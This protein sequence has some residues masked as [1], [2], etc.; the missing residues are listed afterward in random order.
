VGGWAWPR[1]RDELEAVQRE[2][3]AAV[4]EPWTVPDGPY[5]LGAAFVAFSTGRGRAG[6]ER[7]WAVAVNGDARGLAR[8]EVEA[9]YE[10]GYLA[11]REG[12]L[13][14]LAVRSLPA[15]PDVLLVNASGSDHPRGAGLA[16]HLGAVLG[17]PTVGVTDRPL[18][19]QRDPEGRLVLEGR[20]VGHVVVTRPG[21]RPVMAHAAWR[22]DAEVALQVVRSAAGQ[23]RTPETLRLARFLARSQRARDEGRLP[24]GWDMD[25]LARPR[26]R[27]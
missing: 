27:G 5:A 15:L 18:L 9:P 20:V 12:P 7:A 14:E 25:R 17:L 4:P 13:L 8:D 2:L 10:A 21:A 26:F 11:L 1:T 3:S 16:L 19:A 6:A 22:T 23:A 24:E